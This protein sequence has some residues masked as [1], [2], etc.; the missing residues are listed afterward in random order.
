MGVRVGAERVAGARAVEDVL[1]DAGAERARVEDSDASGALNG[2]EGELDGAGR[3]GD[4]LFALGVQAQP[5]HAR[6]LG[7]GDQPDAGAGGGDEAEVGGRGDAR[8]ITEGEGQGRG[9]DPLGG[10][11]AVVLDSG[12]EGAVFDG[13]AQV[14]VAVSGVAGGAV[15]DAHGQRGARC[16]RGGVVR[17]QG[18]GL[19]LGGLA[20]DAGGDAALTAG[21]A[22]CGARAR[23]G[24]RVRAGR[25]AGVS[26]GSRRAGRGGRGAGRSVAVVVRLI[27]GGLVVR[28]V[29]GAGAHAG[30]GGGLRLVGRG[31]RSGLGEARGLVGDVDRVRAS[32]RDGVGGAGV[33]GGPRAGLDGQRVAACAR[34]EPVDVLVGGVGLVDV[35]AAR[36][37]VEAAI[38]GDRLHA[39]GEA[40]GEGVDTA[41]GGTRVGDVEARG[42]VSAGCDAQG[43]P[44]GPQHGGLVIAGLAEQVG[45]G[46]SAGRLADVGGDLG[47]RGLVDGEERLLGLAHDAGA[48]GVLLDAQGER[49]GGV[50]GQVEDVG[51]AAVQGG[52]GTGGGGAH[53]GTGGRVGLGRGR[54][55]VGGGLG[56]FLCCNCI[57]GVGGGLVGGV[58]R[59][60]HEEG[61]GREGH[62]GE[63]PGSCAARVPVLRGVH[64]GVL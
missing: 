4:D 19:G 48:G 24:G 36:R 20:G 25:R 42:V 6:D 10:L 56:G 39:L 47:E 52:R 64:E 53:D 14:E 7:G 41:V 18:G 9:V 38:I 49:A 59:S 60:G 3:A 22:G 31:C 17:G 51:V 12:D 21:R 27:L 57:R 5:R 40:G 32:G 50:G 34:E 61:G 37:Q 26:G 55:C 8:R 43:V 30:C 29:H 54:G 45:R 62:C 35:V 16:V 15:A 28:G 1:A 58:C 33:A 63:S 13:G 23:G 44:S 11:A 2:V 46:G